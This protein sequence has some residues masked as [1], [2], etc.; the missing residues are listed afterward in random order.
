M[1]YGKRLVEDK[2]YGFSPYASWT[3]FFGQGAQRRKLG[4]SKFSRE[5]RKELEEVWCFHKELPN[6]SKFYANTKFALDK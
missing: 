5:K 6:G 3:H 4:G 2:I 1:Q